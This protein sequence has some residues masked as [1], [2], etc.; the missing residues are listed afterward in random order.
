MNRELWEIV[1]TEKG[2]IIRP[3]QDFECPI[4]HHELIL[5]DFWVG[6]DAKKN[7]HHVD[8]H[9]KCPHCSFYSTFGIA[10]SKEQYEILKNSPLHATTLTD[11][12][13]D[14]V[15]LS[16][17]DEKIIRKRLKELGYWG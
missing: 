3:K 10:I 2:V 15:E 14:I 8:V 11:E 17:E 7:F 6:K 12:L 13:T 4:C 5:H 16:E 9:M 1:D